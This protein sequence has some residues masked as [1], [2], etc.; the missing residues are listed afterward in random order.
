MST[1]K[2]G[3]EVVHTE[4]RRELFHCEHALQSLMEIE[5]ENMPGA[6]PDQMATHAS[7]KLMMSPVRQ[8]GRQ[9]SLAEQESEEKAKQHSCEVVLRTVSKSQPVAP[10][11][12]PISTQTREPPQKE[13]VASKSESSHDSVVSKGKEAA[14]D[15][16]KQESLNAIVS[17]PKILEKMPFVQSSEAQG[18]KPHSLQT[19]VPKGLKNGKDMGKIPVKEKTVQT[20]APEAS[21][22]GKGPLNIAGTAPSFVGA[23]EVSEAV[24]AQF[25][26]IE[27]WVQI[28]SGSTRGPQ[29]DRCILEAAEVSSASPSPTA[30]MP[31]KSR[32]VTPG[33]KSSFVTQLTSVAKTVLGPM[34]LGSQDGGKAKDSTKA[35][36]DRRATTLR[37][38][39]VSSG[40]CCGLTGT[41]PSPGSSKPEKASKS[42]SKH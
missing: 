27:E 1:R 21:K 14:R 23:P 20:M 24:P 2:H 29:E 11:L 34:K 35:N 30:R 13:K 37:K 17:G 9:D 31:C 6:P 40:S 39:E 42:S 41:C 3:L 33:D 22:L 26:T 19:D 5:G 25:K 28:S 32:A 10:I 12:D 18:L 15:V 4:Y 38:S 8:L 7:T 16:G 36:E